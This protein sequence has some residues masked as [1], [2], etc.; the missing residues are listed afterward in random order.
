MEVIVKPYL[1][2]HNLN[3]GVIEDTVVGQYF[4]CNGRTARF[5][6]N[7][8]F[9]CQISSLSDVCKWISSNTAPSLLRA[10]YDKA[11]GQ[12]AML[13]IDVQSSYT[14]YVEKYFPN[15]VLKA[16]YK[17]TNG[18]DAAQEVK[19]TPHTCYVNLEG[20]AVVN[21][22]YANVFEYKGL[23]AYILKHV[24]YN[25]QMMAIMSTGDWIS[26]SY[27]PVFLTAILLRS[28][29][30][31]DS[32]DYIKKP[33]ILIDVKD[34]YEKYVDKYFKIPIVKQK[35]KSTND[36]D[37]ILYLVRTEELENLLID[38]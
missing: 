37:M 4:I 35:Y 17:S 22:A 2:Y 20:E 30:T 32:K 26:S 12:R 6:R 7:P 16:P 13:L 23:H 34:G 38:K 21:Q 29:V 9:N 1:R 10:I 27:A 15:P 25:C 24:T 33:M 19:I 8:T 14:K 18:S 36:S 11:S 28:S 5:I 31:A 3:D